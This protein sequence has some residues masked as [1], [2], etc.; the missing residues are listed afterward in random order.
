MEVQFEELKIDLIEK[1]ASIKQKEK[2]LKDL[3]EEKENRKPM[4][5][6]VVRKHQK[7][8]QT[9]K[10]NLRFEKPQNETKM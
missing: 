8:V 2:Q 3:E 4:N 1:T 7:P 10:R 5:R 9:Q 6:Q